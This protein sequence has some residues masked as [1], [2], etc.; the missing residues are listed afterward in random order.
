MD[1]A[2]LQNPDNISQNLEYLQRRSDE[3]RLPV[4]HKF[5]MP[6]SMR[7]MQIVFLFMM[8]GRYQPHITK[9]LN[10]AALQ[11]FNF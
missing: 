5:L 11:V 6:T 1:A 9:S 10:I 3:K 2:K 7:Q 8:F 4:I